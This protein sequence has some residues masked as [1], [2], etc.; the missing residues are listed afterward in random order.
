MKR[1]ITID[2]PESVS[3]AVLELAQFLSS[4]HPET[5]EAASLISVCARMRCGEGSVG[6]Y[7]A[8]PR[9]PGLVAEHLALVCGNAA[10]SMVSAARNLKR[11]TN[12]LTW[13]QAADAIKETVLLLFKEEFGRASKGIGV[14]GGQS[15]GDAYPHS[16][17]GGG[18]E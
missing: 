10:S 15:F 18:G 12:D 6:M 8:Y 16:S 14:S 11:V 7:A 9:E 4:K 3:L 13:E 1:T 2:G 5:G 17:G